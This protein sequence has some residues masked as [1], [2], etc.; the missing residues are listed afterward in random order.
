MLP[1]IH[2][3]S[4]KQTVSATS[5]LNYVTDMVLKLKGELGRIKTEVKKQLSV[6]IFL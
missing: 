2:M 4:P 6:I 3:E 5:Q 1:V